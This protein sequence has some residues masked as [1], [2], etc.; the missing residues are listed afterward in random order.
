MNCDAKV[1]LQPTR[2]RSTVLTAA[3]W[4]ALAIGATAANSQE[5]P[6]AYTIAPPSH[7]TGLKISGFGTLGYWDSTGPDDLVFRR[8]LGQNVPKID[9]NHA[10]ADSRL[11]LQLNYQASERIE[12]VGQLVVR[13]HAHFRADHTIE[14]AFAKFRPT[15]DTQLRLGRVGLD[16]FMLSDYRNVGYAYNWVRPPTEFYGWIPFYSINGGDAVKTLAMADGHLKVKV[17]GGKTEAGL[18]WQAGSYQLGARILGLGATWE[19]DEWRLRA[20]H[21]RLKFTDN[22]PFDQLIPTLQTYASIW[23]TGGEYADDL[24][25]IGQRLHYTVVGAA[26][27]SDGWQISGEFSYTHANTTFAPQGKS[28][29]VSIGRR[30]DK[31]VPFIG[32]ARNW[33]SAKLVLDAPPF[34]GLD[35]AAQSLRDAF[36]STHTDQY[37]ASLGVRWDVADRMAVKVQWDRSVVAINGTQLWGYGSAPWTGKAKQ[38]WS[39]TLDFT[40]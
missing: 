2:S 30:F 35:P 1:G 12:L 18:P 19:N 6:P 34:S 16:M 14:W 40:F 31:W 11:G 8:E 22:A 21:T 9:K 3:I 7:P 23:P 29:Y 20:Y 37:T 25:L 27:E 32:F 15:E 5:A 10:K 13:E 26:W 24:Q 4:A 39:A 17:F 33:D 38:L 36:D 28:A